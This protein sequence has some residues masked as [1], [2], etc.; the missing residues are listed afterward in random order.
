MKLTYIYL[1]SEDI[2]NGFEGSRR[3]TGSSDVT[4]LISRILFVNEELNQVNKEIE[5]TGEDISYEKKF[6]KLYVGILKSAQL[7]YNFLYE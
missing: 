2:N 7:I 3:K 6:V 5:N 1:A 4:A